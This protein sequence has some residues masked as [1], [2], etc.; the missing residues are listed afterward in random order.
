MSKHLHK[1]SSTKYRPLDPTVAAHVVH[2]GG[3][4]QQRRS[5]GPPPSTT[6]NKR[7]GIKRT[8]SWDCDGEDKDQVGIMDDHPRFYPQN[9]VQ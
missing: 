6:L 3:D 8:L 2:G 7:L 9:M 1:S 4:M 5:T